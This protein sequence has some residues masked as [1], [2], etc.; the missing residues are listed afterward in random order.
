MNKLVLFGVVITTFMLMMA[1]CQYKFIVEPVIPPPNPEDT[2]Y[3]STDVLPIWN[4]DNNCTSCHFPGATSPDLTPANVY[5]DITSKGMV[6]TETP[7]QSSI[8]LFPSPET[9]THS[10][11]KYSNAQAATMLQWIEQGA[12]NN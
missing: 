2:V 8:Y 11:K 9:T 6:N 7:D 1:S 4:D 3:F 5:I 10:W 12:L